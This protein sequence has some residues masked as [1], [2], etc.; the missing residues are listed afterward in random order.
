MNKQLLLRR[1]RRLLAP[2]PDHPWW[3][4]HAQYPTVLT[5]SDRRWRVYFAAR[6][7]DNQSRILYA[8]F[9]PARDFELIRVSEEPLLDLGRPGAF[10]SAGMGPSATLRV[11]D[12]IFLYYV[13]IALRPDVPYQ[14]AIGLAISDDGGATFRPGV[15]GPV[16]ATGPFD[17]YFT[18]APHVTRTAEIFRMYYVSAFAWERTRGRPEPRYHIKCAHSIDGISWVTEERVALG[19]ADDSEAAVVRPWII[20]RSDGYHMWFSSRG[21]LG[22]DGLPDPPYRLA[23]A[24]SGDGITWR[25]LDRFLS[26]ENPPQPGDWDSRMQEYPC[27]VADGDEFLVFYNGNGFG[28]AGFGFARARG[29]NDSPSNPTPAT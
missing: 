7:A 27:A 26:F 3:R 20:E 22:E 13:G 21:R 6:G 11:G 9:D 12:R 23:Y 8:D 25:R 5:L 17:P 24:R 19:C 4:S 10:D 18:S 2:L 29:P 1:E 15:P 28:Q 16:L 14:Q